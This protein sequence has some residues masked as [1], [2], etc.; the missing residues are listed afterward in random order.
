VT[1]GGQSYTVG[2]DII[3]KMDG[4]TLNTVADMVKVR[5]HLGSLP[6][7]KTYWIT[8]LRGGKILDLTGLVP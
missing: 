1:V 6:S 2:G 4:I 5:E 7:G 3:L 8:V